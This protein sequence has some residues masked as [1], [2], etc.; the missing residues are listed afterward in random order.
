M[1]KE[2]KYIRVAESI[3]NLLLVGGIPAVTHARVSRSAKVSRAWLYKYVGAKRG[4]LIVYAI[5]HFGKIFIEIGRENLSV[6]TKRE[7]FKN[8]LSTTSR[9]LDHSVQYPW[10]IPIYFHFRNSKSIVGERIRHIVDMYMNAHAAEISKHY[11][12]SKAQAR[13]AAEAFTG[14]RMGLAYSY[15][16]NQM[17]KKVDKRLLMIWIQSVLRIPK[18]P[19]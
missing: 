10:I 6:A 16:V 18:L 13:T 7:Y 17:D 2:K 3:L 5:D 8:T 11:K 12:L 14:M 4:D 9:M 19:R 15:L 1:E